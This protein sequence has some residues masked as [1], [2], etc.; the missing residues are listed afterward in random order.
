MKP[1]NQKILVEG[2][3]SGDCWRACLASILE[4]DI[5]NFPSPRDY[6]AQ[7]DEGWSNYSNAVLQVLSDMG[8]EYYCIPVS[9]LYKDPLLLS[10]SYH[11]QLIAVGESPRSSVE[12]PINHSVVWNNGIIHDPHPDKN[13]IV[14]IKYFEGL[15]KIN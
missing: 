13:G 6:N 10:G 14:N 9:N 1:V 15:I 12:R 11:G 4:C 5:E 8:F 2:E 3:L 7:T